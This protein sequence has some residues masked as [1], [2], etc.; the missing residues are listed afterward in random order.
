[1]KYRKKSKKIVK[2]REILENIGKYWKISESIVK[3]REISWPRLMPIH[4]DIHVRGGLLL[5]S[6]LL[7]L[8][9][10]Q[11]LSWVALLWCPIIVPLH[12]RKTR[13]QEILV[14]KSYYFFRFKLMW[15]LTFTGI[16]FRERQGPKL[17]FASMNFREWALSEW[18]CKYNFAGINFSER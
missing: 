10:Y 7:C 6:I 14:K 16:N 3:Y 13:Y 11:Y 4:P 17:T 18:H 15:V 5:F 8:W 9:T 12:R 1:M 2:Y